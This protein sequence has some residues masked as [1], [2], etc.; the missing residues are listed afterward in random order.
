[1]QFFIISDIEAISLRLL[2]PR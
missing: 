1:M 2:E